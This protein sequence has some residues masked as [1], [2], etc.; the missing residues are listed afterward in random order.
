MKY[1]IDTN[2]LIYW[3]KNK[4][5]TLKKLLSNEDDLAVSSIS[6]AELIYGAKKSLYI[7][8]NMQAAIKILSYF[9]IVDFSKDDAFEYGDIR[10]HLEKQGTPIGD[11]DIQIAAQ[12]RRLGLVVVTANIREFSR[13]RNLCV[14]N[15]TKS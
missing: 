13:I 12:A 7:E 5:D 14:E 4:P 2:I 10:A 3:M 6:V 11:H 15:W 9:N 1:L 8:K